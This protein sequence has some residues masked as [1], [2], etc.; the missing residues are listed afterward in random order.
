MNKKLY[1]EDG[2][3]FIY[4]LKERIG[5]GGDGKIY[6]L[7]ND[8][9]L[10][11]FRSPHFEYARNII[12]IISNLNMDGIYRIYNLLYNNKREFI[13]YEMKYYQKEDIDILTM[14]IDYTIDNLIKLY[15][16]ADIFGKYNIVMHDLLCINIILNSDGIT[17][18]DADGYYFDKYGTKSHNKSNVNSLFRDLY[19]KSLEYNH[20][21]IS[22][23]LTDNIN[24][25][26]A[27]G[28]VERTYKKL[29]K[30]KYPIDYLRK[31]N[32][33]L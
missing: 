20:N 31:N 2:D 12:D 32:N 3:I 19:K 14:P 7:N 33:M 29:I 27:G 17:V 10:K 26:F 6:L 18:I 1:T 21:I 25:L 16:L 13:G 22:R 11:I 9:C 4:N 15:N 8:N 30:Y 24:D 28:N 23:D 5:S